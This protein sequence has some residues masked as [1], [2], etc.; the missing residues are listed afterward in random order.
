L[1]TLASVTVVPTHIGDMISCYAVPVSEVIKVG[2]FFEDL[3]P[4]VTRGS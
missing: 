2:P 3:L 1:I 4:N